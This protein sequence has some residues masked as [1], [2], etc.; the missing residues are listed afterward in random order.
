MFQRSFM[1]P[2]GVD[3]GKIDASFDKGV[4]RISLPKL[5]EAEA[6]IR[7]IAVKSVS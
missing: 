2:T 6:N 4:L 3:S 1:L 7:K 5:P